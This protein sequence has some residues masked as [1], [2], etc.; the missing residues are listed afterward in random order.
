MS[1]TNSA[2][3]SARE[4]GFTL[5]EILVALAIV[6]V[7]VGAALKAASLFSSNAYDLKV[8][9]FAD[10]A[11]QNH[12]NT[13]RLDEA[14]PDLGQSRASCPIANEDFVCVDTVSATVNPLMRRVEIRVVRPNDERVALS[15]LVG[16]LLKPQRR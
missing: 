8:R 14:F 3:T 2:P 1:S 15:R 5:I 9:L 16:T 4:R 10:W 11:A 13:Y 6:A 7:G 12:L